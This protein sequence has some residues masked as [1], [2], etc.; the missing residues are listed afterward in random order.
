MPRE[1][2]FLHITRVWRGVL[3]ESEDT[4]VA[5]ILHNIVEDTPV[6]LSIVKESFGPIVCDAVEALTKQENEPLS[7]YLE[8][9]CAN[10]IARKVK[11]SDA[12]DNYSRLENIDDMETRH[13]L[14]SKYMDTLVH[15]ESA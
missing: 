13:R 6:T 12:R 2:Y 9:V 15:L 14:K 8:R 10:E 4:Q 7:K 3:D 5:A 11:V 1:P